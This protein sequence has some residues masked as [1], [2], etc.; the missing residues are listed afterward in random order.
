MM[1]ENTTPAGPDRDNQNTLSPGNGESLPTATAQ[2][3]TPSEGTD[4]APDPNEQ[5]LSQITKEQAIVER[6]RSVVSSTI[7]QDPDLLRE[8]SEAFIR[9]A[10]PAEDRL[11]FGSAEPPKNFK[12]TTA[13]LLSSR[14]REVLRCYAHGLSRAQ[15]A[16]HTG[17]SF[18]TIANVRRNM[19]IQ[20]RCASIVELIQLAR[21][22]GVI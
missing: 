12:G 5:L 6:L 9:K 22:E 2:D 18:N 10:L 21:L 15:V 8:I 14:E 19:L 7:Q 3:C 17:L 11:F 16:E 13:K 20:S 4:G 1:H